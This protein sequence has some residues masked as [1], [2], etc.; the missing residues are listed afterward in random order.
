[1]SRAEVAA[2]TSTSSRPARPGAATPLPTRQRRPGYVALAVL[3]IV[4]LGA[5]GAWLYG[6][7]GAKVPVVV[8]VRPVPAGHVVERSDVSTVAVAGGITAVAGWNLDSVVGRTAAVPL[9]PDM[10]VQQ[11]MLTSSGAPG[12]GQAQV[13]LAV[14]GGQLPAGGLAPGD[15]VA[16]LQLPPTGTA[17]QA[18][19]AADVLVGRATVFSVRSDPAQAGGSLV[20]VT[21]PTASMTAVAAAG[22]SGAV[23]L[24]KVAAP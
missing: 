24:V 3:L 23:A 5:V 10:L 16:V 12:E 13:G 17:A 4:G 21:V 9:L 19:R 6:E 22:G 15:V 2:R 8:V 11:S 7:A 14:K 1:M 20:T 18:P